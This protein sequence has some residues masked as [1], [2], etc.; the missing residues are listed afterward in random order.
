VTRAIVLVS[1]GAVL[2]VAGVALWSFPASLIVCGV[3][4]VGAGLLIDFEE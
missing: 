2:T 3:V 1:L 4:L